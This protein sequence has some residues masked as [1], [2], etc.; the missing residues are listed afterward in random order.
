MKLKDANN[1]PIHHGRLVADGI[2]IN[3]A[4]TAIC[5]KYVQVEFA[6]SYLISFS[7]LN[8]LAERSDTLPG[9]V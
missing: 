2:Y 3:A 7:N 5:K 4:V 9:R 1:L 8:H 6:K